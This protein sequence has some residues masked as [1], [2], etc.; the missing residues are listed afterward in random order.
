MAKRI[1]ETVNPSTEMQGLTGGVE[2]AQALSPAATA[3]APADGAP[4]PVPGDA[5]AATAAA[6]ADAPQ[7]DAEGNPI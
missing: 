7:F 4:V 6:P 3:A 2:L 1:E 5:P